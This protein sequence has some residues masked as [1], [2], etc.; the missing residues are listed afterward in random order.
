[1]ISRDENGNPRMISVFDWGGR[2]N[3]N[4]M[5]GI[6]AVEVRIGELGNWDLGE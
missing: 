1:L 6:S 5:N 4:S 3:G 2:V